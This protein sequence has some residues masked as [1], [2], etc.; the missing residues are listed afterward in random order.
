MKTLWQDIRYGMRMLGKS[1][2]F[3]AIALI[4]L[5][6][7]IG[8]NTIMFSVV[9]AMVFRPMHVRE[10][11]RIV[12]CGIRDYD[13]L[14]SYAMYAEMRRDNPA[15][16]D[17]VAHNWAGGPS[18]WVRGD[19]VKQMDLMY[20]SSNYFSVLGAAPAYGRTFLPEEESCGAEP[21]VVLNY[22]TWRKEGSDPGIVGQY[23]QI[24]ATLCR[25]VGV[26][27]KGFTGTAAKGPD[28]WLPLGAHGPVAH[29]N[30]DRPTGRAAAIWDY[31]WVLMLG[32]LKP[33]L[34]MPA[35]EARLQA[36]IP[37]LK[38]IEPQGWKDETRLYV[39][40]P[41]R[42]NA[43][44]NEYE[45]KFLPIVSMV[46]MGISGA[47]LLIACL[48]LAGMITVQGAARQ[49]EIAIR[50]AIGGGRLR[51]IR[52][53][54]LESLLLA[55]FGGAL[56]LI[57][58]LWGVRILNV[59]FAKGTM[60]I[61]VATSLDLRALA[62]TLA[63]C[64]IATV[65]FGL[66]PAV[67][68][69]ARNVIRDLKESGGAAIR[70]I[71][72]RRRLIPRGLSVVC[73]IALSVVLVMAATLF[74]RTALNAARADLGFSL[75]GKVVVRIDPLAGGYTKAQAVSACEALAERLRG[76]PGIAA[77]GLS[78]AF[79]IGN[80]D[81]E[82]SQRFIAYKP[83]A[84]DESST[85]LVEKGLMLYSVGDS[86][87]EAMGIP[88]L[89]GRSFNR[90]DLAP[91]AEKVVIIDEQLARKLRPDGNAVD[92]L[93]LHGWGS[94]S[95]LD[96]CRVVGI[97]PDQR[98]LA[99]Q[100][101]N[102]RYIYQPFPDYRLPTYIHLRL[103]KPSSQAETALVRS[104]GAQIRKIDPRLPV[105]SVMSL[106]DLRLG[107]SGVRQT[108]MTAKLATMFG[109]MAL[110]LAGLGLY[111]IKGHMV[112]SQTPEI[113]I[114][115]ALGATRRNIL[116]M[117]FRQGAASTCA[118]L[119]IGIVL[120]IALARLIRA[121]FYG[122]SPMDPV[123]IVATVTLLTLVSLLAGYVPARRAARIDPM[124]ALRCE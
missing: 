99:G 42:L 124:T 94:N 119:L 17:L 86:Y 77:A 95:E 39:S 24:N 70:S 67:S 93:I 56:A 105:V 25:I 73:Q 90:L 5:A 76:M 14:V 100:V 92:C 41:S 113:G 112:A 27:P 66:K 102:W 4:T 89:Q 21:V 108:R 35:A 58:A 44:D 65:L 52:Q 115:M 106:T 28:L 30:E 79:P 3:T 61:H 98:D 71:R 114:R 29:Y 43:G 12:Y 40:R 121:G 47:I 81:P 49:R 78:S 50:M 10:P 32:R 6:V 118:G 20:V 63:F 60:P 23:V 57:P 111:A 85:N 116:A 11:D 68:L 45:R 64:L 55:L 38:D 34:D 8:A 87:L 69:S 31:P 74:T 16:S 9:D 1:P 101:M 83:G 48:N 88:L 103:A 22:E 123:S 107:N 2:G 26:A 91:D 54:F 51:I 13:L 19:A 72:R 7:G 122:V 110:F 80:T 15:F 82:L 36:L 97:V 117:V 53:L 109:T 84:E 96:L 120:A 104:L 59:W 75:D 18:T 62:A 33:G 46:L 37:R